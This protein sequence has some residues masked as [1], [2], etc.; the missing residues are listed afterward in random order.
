M[1]RLSRGAS[2]ALLLLG[3]ALIAAQQGVLIATGTRTAVILVVLEDFALICTALVSR[4]DVLLYVFVFLLPFGAVLQIGSGGTGRTLL[5]L[6]GGAVAFAWLASACLTRLN[7]VVFPELKWLGLFLVCVVTS[8]IAG[9]D[10]SS[11]IPPTQSFI[12]FGVMVFLC[13]Q[14]VRS[15][16]QFVVLGWVVIASLSCVGLL[17]I[18]DA[19]TGVTF[20]GTRAP[21]EYTSNGR[22]FVRYSSIAGAGP[23]TAGLL[24]ALGLLLCFGYFQ[25][26]RRTYRVRIVLVSLAAVFAVAE[27]LA[28]SLSALAGLVIGIVVLTPRRTQSRLALNLKRF[29]IVAGVVLFATS[30]LTAF[31]DRIDRQ[32][33]T[34]KLQ[35]TDHWGSQRI[36]LWVAAAD[37]IRRWPLLGVGPGNGPAYVADNIPQRLEPEARRNGHNMYLEVGDDSGLIGLLLFSIVTLGATRRAA[38]AAQIASDDKASMAEILSRSVYSCLVVLIV[39]GMTSGLQTYPH[40]W[41]TVALAVIVGRLTDDQTHSAPVS[42][43]DSMVPSPS[44]E[45]STKGEDRATLT[46]ANV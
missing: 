30:P 18:L 17:M 36:G 13:A 3:S 40:L 1:R 22:S 27:V 21:L 8:A 24:M 46:S 2:H 6:A 20:G 34:V 4:I 45:E 42:S 32:E 12:L 9:K 41:L 38:R 14:I 37:V 35:S 16:R 25:V 5:P 10:L 19:A 29:L 44:L 28:Y 39:V 26:Y 11:S 7:L 15:W 31:Q 33:E 23:N 43:A